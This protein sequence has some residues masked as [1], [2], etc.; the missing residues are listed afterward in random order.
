MFNK[1]LGEDCPAKKEHLQKE[2]IWKWSG[3]GEALHSFL[4][5]PHSAPNCLSLCFYPTQF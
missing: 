4:I 5:L 3:T 1:T 2:T